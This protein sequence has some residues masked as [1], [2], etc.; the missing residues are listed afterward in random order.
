MQLPQLD[1]LVKDKENVLTCAR[2]S[3]VH[4]VVEALFLG[5]QL[6][7]LVVQKIEDPAGRGYGVDV[8]TLR[9]ADRSFVVAAS[10]GRH[11]WTRIGFR[12]S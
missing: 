1:Y 8:L 2:S 11:G 3:F 10:V 4:L 6:P 12:M 9:P 5:P 7:F